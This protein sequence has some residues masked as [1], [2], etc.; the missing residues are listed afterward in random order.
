MLREKALQLGRLLG[1]KRGLISMNPTHAVGPEL[2][3]QP[4][5]TG[6]GRKS[7]GLERLSLARHL[8]LPMGGGRTSQKGQWSTVYGVTIAI[9]SGDISLIY[10]SPQPK[11]NASGEPRFPTISREARGEKGNE[12]PRLSASGIP[13]VYYG[14]CYYLTA[15]R[16]I[17]RQCG[18]WARA[19]FARVS[20]VRSGLFVEGVFV[21]GV[22]VEAE[23][24]ELDAILE[25]QGAGAA[26]RGLFVGHGVFAVV[27]RSHIHWVIDS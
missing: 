2:M 4:L 1:L 22:F 25:G 27:E 24:E 16:E 14:G 6:E 8:D 20:P 26:A 3:A 7:T 10:A 17:S 21:E 12:R 5:H 19:L 18:S 13:C 9:G 11:P 23:N 15:R